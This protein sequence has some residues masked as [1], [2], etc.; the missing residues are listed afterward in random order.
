MISY[1]GFGWKDEHLIYQ[2]L[3]DKSN[4]IVG[5][6]NRER[7]CNCQFIFN[8]DGEQITVETKSSL[9]DH[10]VKKLEI[11]SRVMLGTYLSATRALGI[12]TL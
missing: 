3:N 1:F 9:P 2:W 8:V 12:L 4:Y 5:A 6:Q 11:A 10:E 7:E